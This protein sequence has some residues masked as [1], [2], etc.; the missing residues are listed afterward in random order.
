MPLQFAR[1][2][3]CLKSVRFWLVVFSMTVFAAV[4]PGRAEGQ[5]GSNVVAVANAEPITRKT[6]ADESVKRYGAD[7]LD[8]MVN[9]Q[10]IMQECVNRG[11]EVSNQEAIRSLFRCG[12]FNTRCETPANHLP[13]QPAC[14]SC[15]HHRL[16]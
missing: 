16:D 13:I 14:S 8:N 4:M 12:F 10:L 11:V 1:I 6:L 15:C 5:E 9:R 3:P 7:V 2:Q